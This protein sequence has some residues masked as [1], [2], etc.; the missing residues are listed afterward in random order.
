MKEML[1][2]MIATSQRAL[3][4]G[5]VKEMKIYYCNQQMTNLYGVTMDTSKNFMNIFQEENRNLKRILVKQI[6]KKESSFF[7]TL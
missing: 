7:I 3:V 5:D 6:K 2:S 4:L 1:Y